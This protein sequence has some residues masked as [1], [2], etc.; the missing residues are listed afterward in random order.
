MQDLSFDVATGVTLL[1]QFTDAN[2]SNN[3][4]ACLAQID[5]TVRGDVTG[6]VASSGFTYPYFATLALWK[7]N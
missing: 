7:L 5:H 6:T 4:R 1:H 3:H 2:P